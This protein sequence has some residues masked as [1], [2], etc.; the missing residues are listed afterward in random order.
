MTSCL[1]TSCE[2]GP[3]SWVFVPPVTCFSLGCLVAAGAH[4][5]ILCSF[6]SDL[7]LVDTQCFWLQLVLIIFERLSFSQDLLW[8]LC[9]FRLDCAASAV[10]CRHGGRGGIWV[11]PH[12]WEELVIS[13]QADCFT[14]GI[15]SLCF[16]EQGGCRTSSWLWIWSMALKQR[17]TRRYVPW[18]PALQA[19]LSQHSRDAFVDLGSWWEAVFPVVM[20][21]CLQTT[22]AVKLCVLREKKKKDK[23]QLELILYSG[24]WSLMCEFLH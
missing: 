9:I 14:Q 1:F 2:H 5:L 10:S 24:N 16:Q 20:K 13:W 15:L 17:T 11:L 19:S 8:S 7:H 12:W 4:V 21:A 23:H 22:I 3:P 18:L 6:Y